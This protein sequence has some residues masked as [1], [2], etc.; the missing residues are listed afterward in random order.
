METKEVTTW[1]D[2]TALWRFQI[3]APLLDPALDRDKKIQMRKDLAARNDL[4]ERLSA[5]T[6]PATRKKALPD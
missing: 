3:I 4:S 5:D 1:R 2:D 6:N